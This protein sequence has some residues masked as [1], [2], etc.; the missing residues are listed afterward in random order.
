MGQFSW[1]TC[2]HQACHKRETRR[3][4]AGGGDGTNGAEVG[5]MY[6]EDGGKGH[7]P[8]NAGGW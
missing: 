8:G 6:F 1:I 4:K 7:E 5:V 2:N 3:S